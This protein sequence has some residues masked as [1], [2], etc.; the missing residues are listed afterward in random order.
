MPSPTDWITAVATSLLAFMAIFTWIGTFKIF[1]RSSQNDEEI[2]FPHSSLSGEEIFKLRKRVKELEDWKLQ[3]RVK[4]LEDLGLPTRVKK[5]ED[6]NLVYTKAFEDIA[7]L[8]G[9]PTETDES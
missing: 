2:L 7:K 3:T 8:I 9:T 4:G 5:L 6:L 1:H